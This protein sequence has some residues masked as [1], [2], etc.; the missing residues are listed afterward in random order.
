[1]LGVWGMKMSG[2]HFHQELLNFKSLK[3]TAVGPYRWLALRSFS[4]PQAATVGKLTVLLRN[5]QISSSLAPPHDAISTHPISS[6]HAGIYN[7]TSSQ[8]DG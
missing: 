2:K 7:L 8:G 6:H 3:Y 1:M 4:P 5:C